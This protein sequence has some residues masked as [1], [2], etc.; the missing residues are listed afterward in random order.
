MVNGADSAL[1]SDHL[2]QAQEHD[3][4]NA[5]CRSDEPIDNLSRH[6]EP[7]DSKLVGLVHDLGNLI[8]VASSAINLISRNIGEPDADLQPLVYGAKAALERASTVVRQTIADARPGPRTVTNVSA[9]LAELGALTTHM[10]SAAQRL[11]IRTSSDDLTVACDPQDLQNAVLNLIINA[12]EAMPDGGKVVVLAAQAPLLHDRIEIRVI[13]TGAGMTKEKTER[14][15]Q[16]NFT[17]KRNGVGGIGLTMVK[18]FV[19]STGGE[20]RVE[21]QL[22]RGTVMTLQLPAAIS[23]ARNCS[24]SPSGAC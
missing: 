8:Q 12:R 17:T 15:F 14:I 21:S 20:V 16:P 19:E 7:Y 24:W 11:E 13:D 6:A 10:W 4:S 22:G 5:P 3:M 18:N 2:A 1:P 23:A 9:C